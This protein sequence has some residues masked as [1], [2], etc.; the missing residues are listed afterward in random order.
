MRTY[1]LHAAVGMVRH[2]ASPSEARPAEFRGDD[3]PPWRAYRSGRD[4]IRRAEDGDAGRAEGGG[5]VHDAAVVGDGGPDGGEDGHQFGEAGPSGHIEGIGVGAKNGGGLRTLLRRADDNKTAAARG[6]PARHGGEMLFRPLFGGAKGRA[7]RQGQPRLVRPDA[8]LL[9]QFRAACEGRAVGPPF[10]G[11]EG[12]DELEIV[13]EL[14]ES[15]RIMASFPF[16]NGVCQKN[17]RQ[18]PRRP[19]RRGM[20][21]R[22]TSQADAKEFGKTTARPSRLSLAA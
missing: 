17:E 10:N 6:M 22:R 20:P 8:K 7:R 16:G 1:L 14:M 12:S 4:W 18:R 2:R 15:G 9:R 5:Q 11:A 13:A 19:R 3:K 21:V